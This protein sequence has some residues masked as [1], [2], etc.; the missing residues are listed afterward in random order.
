MRQKA[1]SFFHLGDLL[2]QIIKN[3]IVDDQTSLM[4]LRTKW[5]EWVGP[6]LNRHTEP[7][8]IYNTKLIVEVSESVWAQE[9]DFLKSTLLAKIQKELPHLKI[10]EMR[11]HVSVKKRL[12]S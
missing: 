7:V 1:K 12:S 9:L 5:P 10:Q 2:P 6:I 3:P 4:D 8:K 11:T